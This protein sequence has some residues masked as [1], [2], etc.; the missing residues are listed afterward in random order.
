MQILNIGCG[1]KTSQH[2]SV[3]N[4]DWSIYLRLRR[5]RIARRAAQLILRGERRERL[6]SLGDNV[7]LHD[8]RKGLPF[9]SD[10]VDVVYHSH[11]LEHLDRPYAGTFLREVH[12]VLRR[13]GIHRIVVPDF[14]AT[15]RKYL[16]H[17]ALCDGDASR[18]SEHESY[19][20]D[21]IEQSVRRE[22]A[23]TSQQSPALRW[24]ENRVL[25]DARKRGETHQWMYDRISLAQL[26]S[27]SGFREPQV[28]SHSRSGI[29]G[30][31]ELGL[32]VDALGREYKPGSLYMECTK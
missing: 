13:S 16:D 25:G 28:V 12:R 23:G 7:R 18:H 27:S 29:E 8:L 15:C 19:I 11:F 6:L 21:V 2:A 17:V 26:L 1:T 9:E 10:T 24:V 4:L 31:L 32:D 30:W 5:N 22:A 14:E 20:A 3:I